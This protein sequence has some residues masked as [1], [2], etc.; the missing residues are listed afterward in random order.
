V[1]GIVSAVQRRFT[2]K[3][4]PFAMF[5][6]EDLAGGIGVIAFPAVL[7]RV[8]NLVEPDAV[9]LV[10]GRVDLRGREMALRAV[11][12]TEPS[13]AERRDPEPEGTLVVELAAANC[14]PSAIAK[15][16]ELLSASPGRT[17]V[18]VRFVSGHGVTPLDVGS[19]RVAAGAGLLSEL[20]VLFGARAVQLEPQPTASPIVSVP[21]PSGA[22]AS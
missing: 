8:P 17:P 22:R 16:K 12:I 4:E 20:R 2:R 11:E 14:T 19:F 15:L 9:V 21:E 18:R 3:G 13:F 10:K 7:E 6:L 1:G 5:R